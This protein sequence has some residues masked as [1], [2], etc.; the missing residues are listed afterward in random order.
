MQ[1]ELLQQVNELITNSLQTAIVRGLLD[2]ES[3][4][5]KR[6][7]RGDRSKLPYRQL[8]AF[9]LTSRAFLDMTREEAADVMG[10]SPETVHVLLDTLYANTPALAFE[11]AWKPPTRIQVRWEELSEED[12]V[13]KF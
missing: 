13:M 8:Q 1:R 10:I 7:I 2:K 6:V 9:V 5:G 12:V 4:L 3:E 11:E